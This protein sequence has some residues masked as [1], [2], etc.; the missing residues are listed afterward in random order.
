[1]NY[2]IIIAKLCK[3]DFTKRIQ[4]SI[5]FIWWCFSFCWDTRTRTRKGRTRIC[6]VTITPYPN[7]YV[8]VK[9]CCN[10]VPLRF[11]VQNY[12]F[13][14]KLPNFFATFFEKTFKK[15]N[16]CRISIRFYSFLPIKAWIIHGKRTI[17]LRKSLIFLHE[18]VATYESI[19]FTLQYDRYYTV[20]W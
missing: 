16:N 12:Y 10:Q 7:R 6:S 1:M 2:V 17:N 4:K 20:I 8:C 9:T 15:R 13:L 11:Q 14:V 19:A 18:K 3:V 5:I